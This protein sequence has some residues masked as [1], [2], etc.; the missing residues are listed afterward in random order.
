MNKCDSLEYRQSKPDHAIVI[1]GYNFGKDTKNGFLVE[2]SWGEENKGKNKAEFKENYYMAEEWFKDYVYL[3]VVDKK[4]VSKKEYDV[5]KKK[6][7]ILP[8]WS[9]FGVVLKG[10][11]K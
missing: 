5:L 11:I 3:V 10:G 4:C 8:Y 9:P 6:P 2:N 7:I 1:R